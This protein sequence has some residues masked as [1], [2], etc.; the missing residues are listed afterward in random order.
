MSDTESGGAR[1]EPRPGQKL[2][3]VGLGASAGGIEALRAFF[4]HVP[5]DSG[6]AYVVILHLSP[7]HDSKL[8]EVLQ[9][10]AA[11]PVTQVTQPVRVEG[12]HVYVVPPNRRLEI[13]DGMLTLSEMTQREHRRSP[14]DVFFRALADANGSR[15]VG[16][17]LSGTGPNGSAGLK[18]VKEYGGL[19]IAHAPEE[20]GDAEMA[21]NA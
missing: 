12:N 21:R 17:V 18:R 15:S 1:F 10:T 8:A 14:V 7:D 3:V 16:V 13:V 19:A 9:T 6:A 4:A 11:I 5:G 20:C 2:L